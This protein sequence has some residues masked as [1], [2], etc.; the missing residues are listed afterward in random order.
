MRSY[1]RLISLGLNCEITYQLN[2][3]FG[4]V[5]SSLFHWA[6]VPA[7]ELISTLKNPALIFSHKII[8]V[9]ETNM[10]RCAVTSI[11]FHGAHLP[12]E[13]LDENGKRDK[14]KIRME[15]KDIF[16]RIDYLRDKFCV[17]ARS[18]ESKLYILGLNPDLCY[19]IEPVSFIQDL[20]ETLQT[21]A[22]NA[23]LL[24]IAEE[25]ARTKLSPLDNDKDLFVRYLN[26]FAPGDKVTN[27]Y[28]VDLKHAK[29]IFS[30]F[31]PARPL[32]KKDKT[33]KFERERQ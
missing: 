22:E 30:E 14:E 18:K 29:E 31:V 21:V 24:V 12:E 5:E 19:N 3:I 20:F 27:P 28:Y 16:S 1:D 13:L 7:K 6:N 11:S 8:E 33:Y 4:S 15:L 10:W 32:P 25:N 17:T 26:T 9:P 23:S 2:K